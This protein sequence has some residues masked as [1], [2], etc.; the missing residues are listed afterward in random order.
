MRD[1]TT[2][3]CTETEFFHSLLI[4]R[5]ALGMRGQ[6]KKRIDDRSFRMSVVTT[7]VSRL[8]DDARR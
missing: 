5:E 4:G 7:H 3:H 8:T 2:E 6:A 1:I